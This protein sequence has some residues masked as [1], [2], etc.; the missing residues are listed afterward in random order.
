MP[1]PNHHP[2]PL[3]R[4]P[5]LLCHPP[6][7]LYHPRTTLCLQAPA[8]GEDDYRVCLA[9]GVVEKGDKVPCPVD[10]NGCFTQ[11]VTEFAGM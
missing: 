9:H 6:D 5:D 7:H 4:P 8:F 11:Q 10:L 3:H 1:P 2:D